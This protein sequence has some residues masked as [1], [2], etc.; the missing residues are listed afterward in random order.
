MQM[1]PDIEIQKNGLCF[2]Y[3]VPSNAMI[4]TAKT[5][6]I[7]ALIKSNEHFLEFK[8]SSRFLYVFFTFKSNESILI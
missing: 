2:L 5:T 3:F 6:N 1:T 4:G 7:T 8:K